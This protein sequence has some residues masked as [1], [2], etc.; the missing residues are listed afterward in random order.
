[1]LKFKSWEEKKKKFRYKNEERYRLQPTLV[2]VSNDNR[3]YKNMFR[4]VW[5]Q[6][7]CDK[8]YKKHKD[9]HITPLFRCEVP[10][11]NNRR[12]FLI[13][14]FFSPHFCE[15]QVSRTWVYQDNESENRQ[16]F[17]EN[18]Q[19]LLYHTTLCLYPSWPIWPDIEVC[20]SN[21]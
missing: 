8:H 10:R 18:C 7:K 5:Y 19:I 12:K 13:I 6:D 9:N 21:F 3:S 17:R 11:A 4:I 1:M 15:S 16:Q 14:N 2:A 20:P